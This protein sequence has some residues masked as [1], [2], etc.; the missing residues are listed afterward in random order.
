MKSLAFFASLLL[1][2]AQSLLGYALEGQ[3]WTRNRTVV[4]QMSL[5]APRTLSDGFTSFDQSAQ[6]AL[7]LWNANLEHLHCTAVLAS[8]VVPDS[9][10]DENSVFFAATVFGDS[11]GSGVLAVTLLSFRGT[12]LEETDTAFNTAY[13]WDSY[14][15]SFNSSVLDFHRVALH[16]FGHSLG[17][18]H[19]DQAG[20]NVAAIMN[21]R[22][23]S[24]DHLE[25]DDIAGAHALYDIGPTYLMGVDAP[26]LANI[27]TRGLVGTGSNVM[28][29]G[30]IVQGSEPATVILRAIGFSLSAVGISGP[31]YDPTIT[32]YDAN[33][34]QV[35]TNDDWA[36]TGADAETIASYQLDPPNS[37]E[38]ALFL[39]LQPGAYT[40]V[41]E[42]FTNAQTPPSSGVGLFELYDVHTSGGR[43]GNISTRGQVLSADNIM[44]GGFIIGGGQ[45]KT[46][47]ARALGPSLGVAG[48]S[49]PLADPTLE[50]RD[51]NGNLLKSNNDWQQGADAQAITDAGLAPSNAKEAAVL[52]TLA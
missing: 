5:G 26:V 52:A 16:E 42:G 13:T 10:D 41:V 30:F 24:I 45:T 39:T 37:R 48:V 50:L 8:P 6:D 3:S 4:F 9:G 44:I 2:S 47:I 11:F 28:I 18:D 31:L 12:V 22:I 33:Q 29:G 25:A 40:A 51:G 15:G 32:V 21:S 46:V 17:L 19:P 36:F 27:S 38:S 34:H 23:S 1:L 35:A 20:Q 14:R 43:A 49:N 7:N